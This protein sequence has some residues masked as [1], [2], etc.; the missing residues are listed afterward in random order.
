MP[1]NVVVAITVNHAI[2]LKKNYILNSNRLT[3]IFIIYKNLKFKFPAI[4]PFHENHSEQKII[5]QFRKKF[6]NF[7]KI[8]KF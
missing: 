2:S 7:I 5:P 6:S 8:L 3:L 4:P 1:K